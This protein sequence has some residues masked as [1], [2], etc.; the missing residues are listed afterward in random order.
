[1]VEP[2]TA[3]G[4]AAVVRTHLDELTGPLGIYQHARA[5][6]PNLGQGYC[7]DDVARAVIVDVLHGRVLGRSAV[8]VSLATSIQFLIEAL[9]PSS[10]RF[11]NFRDADGNWLEQMGSADAHARA[12]Q[13]LGV[14][15]GNDPD[16][17]PAAVRLFADVLN[18][19]LQLDGLRPWAHVLLGC[20]AALAGDQPPAAAAAVLTE[21]ARR[22]AGA[23]AAT[24]PAWPW[25]E[26]VVTYES[27]ILGHALLAAGERLGDPAMSQLGLDTLDWLIRAQV[28]SAGH[29][30]L[31]GN[32]G[33]WPRGATPARFDQQPIDAAALVE[34]CAAAWAATGERRWLD[35][36]H[37][38]YGW[39]LGANAVGIAVADPE[40]GG[41]CDGLSPIGVNAN[42]GAESTLA[43]LTAT[44]V[45]R[46]T[47]G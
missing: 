34:A 9:V 17:Q 3:A 18:V 15:A 21:M 11:R 28:S 22:L 26:T 8:D 5:S 35:E 37:R 6:S 4:P 40:R 25:P 42:Q 10:G 44:E 12:V 16:G 29:L 45:V 23:F 39:F 2:L 31:I 14:V 1:L 19:S 20:D 30:D 46:A 43:W 13:A 24:D 32:L 36:M 47:P 41:C 27:A 33:W 7:T 38:A